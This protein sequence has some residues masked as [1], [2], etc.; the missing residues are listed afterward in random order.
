M[1]YFRKLEINFNKNIRLSCE[2]IFDKFQ[3]C[4]KENKHV[5]YLCN[6]EKILFNKCIIEFSNDFYNKN[7]LYKNNI[8][9]IF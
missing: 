9:I 4:L 6:N 1:N 5:S 8:T 7:H 2:K 3:K